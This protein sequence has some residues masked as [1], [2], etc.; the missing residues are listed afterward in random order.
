MRASSE[1][2]DSPRDEHGSLGRGVGAMV[3]VRKGTFDDQEAAEAHSH[4]DPAGTEHLDSS[5]IVH[6]CEGEDNAFAEEL[7]HELQ[8]PGAD[9]QRG[10]AG[11]GQATGAREAEVR[12]WDV[13]HGP[14]KEGVSRLTMVIPAIA[15]IATTLVGGTL[16]TTGYAAGKISETAGVGKAIDS[17]AFRAGFTSWMWSNGIFPSVRYEPLG[18]AGK[19]IAGMYSLPNEPSESDMSI[20]PLIVSNHICYLDGLVLASV[21]GAPKIVAM[22][23]A[24]RTPIIGKLMEEMEVVFVDRGE[25]GS[26]Q[27]TLDAIVQHCSAWTPGGRP[28]LIFPEGTTT[29][30]EDLISFKRGAFVAGAP[31]RPVLI[32]YTGQWDPA[33]TTYVATG[34]AASKTSDLEWGAQF[35]GHF[36]HSMHV[37]VLP[38]YVPSEAERAD[39]ELYAQNCKSHMATALSRLREELRQ[40]S[41]KEAAG[42]EVGGLDYRFGDLTR[43]AF[44]RVVGGLGAL[45][46]GAPREKGDGGLCPPGCPGL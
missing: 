19:D 37:R 24:Q 2:A 6:E 15:R 26:R 43:I 12:P 17:K 10:A 18:E 16:A 30:G 42:R 45:S 1:M 25:K 28:L 39:A 46:C 33:S 3:L 40:E 21:F 22:K 41:W 36:V 44:R 27:A 23:G 13:A 38:P 35:M 9:V 7:A 8:Q 32:V 4:A 29:N 31:V 20:T 5:P 11:G 34:D 14:R